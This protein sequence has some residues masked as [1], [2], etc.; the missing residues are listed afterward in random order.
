[1]LTYLVCNCTSHISQNVRSVFCLNLTRVSICT[2]ELSVDF[3]E[4]DAMIDKNVANWVLIYFAI[5]HLLMFYSF[6]L[7]EQKQSII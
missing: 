7:G 6:A 1:M 5:T 4:N 3:I 2:F